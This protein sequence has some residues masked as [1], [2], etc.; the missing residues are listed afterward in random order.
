MAADFLVANPNAINLPGTGV[1]TNF[2]VFIS[3]YIPAG[4][5]IGSSS[6]S[7]L[8]FLK[9]IPDDD[10]DLIHDPKIES[11][12]LKK[13]LI[14]VILITCVALICVWSIRPRIRDIH[15]AEHTLLTRPDI[16]SM[17]WIQENLPSDAKFLVN[18]F[19]AY[20]GTLVAGSDGGWWLPL[21][22]SMESSQPPLLYGA[23]TANQPDFIQSTNQLIALITEKGIDHPDVLTELKDRNITHVYIGQ[24]QGQVNTTTP[25]LNVQT[26]IESS[27]YSPIFHQDRVWI[28]SID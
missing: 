5:L 2:A 20:G 7:L 16:R 13:N 25:L 27:N 3:A 12:N 11:G 14:S 28:F 19:F 21:L 26:L 6:A 22:T 24:L 4:I 9:I 17:E 8:T 23:E 1:I 18:S 15:P 10:L